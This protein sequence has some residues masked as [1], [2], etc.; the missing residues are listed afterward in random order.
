MINTDKNLSSEELYQWISE[1]HSADLSTMPVGSLATVDDKYQPHSRTVAIREINENGVLFFTQKGS[2]K[3]EHINKNSFVALTIILSK[4]MR[5]ISFRG[6]AQALSDSENESYW[7]T[8]PKTSQIRFM[9]YGPRSGEAI[10]SNHELNIQVAELKAKY[11]ESSLP[12]PES[13]VGYRIIPTDIELYQ[14]NTERIS[15]SYVLH[16]KDLEWEINRVVP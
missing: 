14:F 4:N 8:Y 1:W 3:V 15:D 10:P 6:Q 7:N 5:Q 16:K 12:R 9:V 13:Y 2:K 11:L